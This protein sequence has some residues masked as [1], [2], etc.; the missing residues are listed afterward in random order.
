MRTALIGYGRLRIYGGNTEPNGA[1]VAEPLRR[2]FRSLAALPVSPPH[3]AVQRHSNSARFAARLFIGE[4]EGLPKFIAVAVGSFADPTFSSPK[5][6]SRS[7][8]DIAGFS[9]INIR[10]DFPGAP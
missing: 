5:T 3:G 9:P 4:A 10:V 1:V 7:G 6:L 2:R 8:G